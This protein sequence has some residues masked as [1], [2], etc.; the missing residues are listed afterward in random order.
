MVPPVTGQIETATFTTDLV[1]QK[2]R[3][4]CLKKKKKKR[5]GGLATV[6]GEH[7]VH[8]QLAFIDHMNVI[9]KH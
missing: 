4:N 1:H 9:Q 3:R 6:Q 5:N 8:Y 2:K 7:L